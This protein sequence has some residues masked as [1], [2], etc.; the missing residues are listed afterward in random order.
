MSKYVNNERDAPYQI[1][2]GSMNHIDCVLWTLALWPELNI[3]LYPPAMES[4]YLFCFCDD[5]RIPEGGQKAKAMV[6][7]RM[8]RNCCWACTVFGSLLVRMLGCAVSTKMKKKALGVGGKVE[9]MCQMLIMI[10]SC[11][12]QMQRLLLFCAVAV[13]VSTKL[14]QWS[15]WQ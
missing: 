6:R 7:R 4:P 10:Q 2:L 3:K 1:I 5:F 11:R 14:I 9:V 12:I 8:Q 15:T 13:H